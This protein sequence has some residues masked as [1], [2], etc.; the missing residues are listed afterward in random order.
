MPNVKFGKSTAT[1][2]SARV[3]L[4]DALIVKQGLRALSFDTSPREG[5]LIIRPRL[6]DLL[7]VFLLSSAGA[8]ASPFRS[9]M[10]SVRPLKILLLILF[11][12]QSIAVSG[13]TPQSPPPVAAAR[14][15]TA[16]DD[17]GRRREAFEIVWRTVK[18]NHFDPTFGGVDWDAVRVEFAPLVERARSD[19]EA[20]SLFQLMLNRL[21]KSHFN[22]I[23]PESIP[24][25]ETEDEADDAGVEDERAAP[26]PRT[27]GSLEMTERLT[28]GIGI[29]LRVVAG[30]G[31]I[32]RVEEGSTAA[33]AGLRPGFVLRS[34]D[35]Y[36]MTTILRL[37]ERAAVYEPAVRHQIPAQI[38]VE[39]VNGAPETSVRLT[40]LDARSRVRRA[41]LRR[42]RLRGE[43]SQ[44]TQSL[45]P[46]FVE[47][48]AK[49]LRDGIGY[50]RFN[51]FVAP[52]LDKFC[53][54]LRSMKDAPGVVIDL[55]G[56]R[57]GLLGLIYGLGGLI[58]TRAVSFGTMRTREGLYE[59]RVIPQRSAYRGQIAVIVDST[60]QSAG[61]IFA[62]GLQDSARAVI[63][64]ERSAG[65]TLPSVAKEL[66]TGA[67]LQYAFADFVTANRQHLE[68]RGVTP[69]VAVKLDRRS[70]LAG[71]DPQLEAALGTID[72]R[73]GA[74]TLASPPAVAPEATETADDEAATG[75]GRE[76]EKE[77]RVGIDPRVEPI[78]EKYT[79]A[80]GGRAAFE[81]LST[82]ISKGTFA[83]SFAGVA[84][85]G[86]VEVLEKAPDKAVTLVKVSGLGV[87]RRGFTGRYAYEQI[88]LFG[89]RQI[90]G[91]E[92][93][94][95]RLTSEL[96]WPVNL[97]RL[98]PTMTL[99]GT[100]K[101]GD[102]EVFVVEAMPERGSAATLYFD[103]R[104]GLLVRRD[105]M[106][107]EDY[108]EVDGV[109]LPFRMRD[110]FAVTTLTEITH[111]LV[112]DDAR[113]VEEKNC[114]TQ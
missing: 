86:T 79:G 34:V 11:A 98:Y 72:T 41:V 8:T 100:E 4:F 106:Y 54:A 49:R 108:R 20:H 81:K 61:E 114:F 53:T 40:Y 71:R 80:V 16:S 65:A 7:S 96:A 56:N 42:E 50:I 112:V 18:E 89:F 99:K 12:F 21:G 32:T 25:T 36:R 93:A 74:E 44:A 37:I 59:F 110:E 6:R 90:E 88:P 78:I 75:A 85:N 29:D 104:T 101:I 62:S 33:R 94:D 45:P 111:N 97:R 57:G 66:P 87:M 92:L 9:R 107:F 113:L 109:R 67:I 91:R 68:G 39:F 22:I 46:Q 1:Q 83:G 17:A 10:L 63:I 14:V 26:K 19:R 27:R 38:L 5:A 31:V 76:E 84:V 77:R 35:G 95:V 24:S 3:E 102:A 48:E 30:A 69:N 15:E 73:A 43:L 64:G 70:L 28:Y 60:T 13:Q 103:T 82:R 23:P 58:E 55:R 52:V 105:K 47:F 2:V 51:L